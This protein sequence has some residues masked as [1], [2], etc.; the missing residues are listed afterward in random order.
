VPDYSRYQGDVDIYIDD[1]KVALTLIQQLDLNGYLMDDC[2]EVYRRPDHRVI[3][4]VFISGMDSIGIHSCGYPIGPTRHPIFLQLQLRQRALRVKT[5]SGNT[6]NVPSVEDTIFILLLHILRHGY[7]LDRDLNDLYM[8][9]K[10]NNI[11]MQ[12]LEVLLK[13]HCLWTLFETLMCDVEDIYSISQ[14]A[15]KR[16]GIHR[17][18]SMFLERG[19]YRGIT[20]S[21]LI[22]FYTLLSQHSS[23]SIGFKF[24]RTFS[25]QL[26]TRNRFSR[27]WF[28]KVNDRLW[29]KLFPNDYELI[30]YDDI[31]SFLLHEK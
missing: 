21:M 30:I 28:R 12:Y 15:I 31:N 3:F 27:K 6:I 13:K 9:L 4:A 18:L 7:K 24:I 19:K 25:D 20:G 29:H 22:Q 17:I 5:N 11:D 26:M 16:R 8:L 2:F 23:N 1:D 10:Y 14:L